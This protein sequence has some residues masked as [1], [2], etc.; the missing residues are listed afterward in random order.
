MVG[1][2]AVALVVRL[3]LVAATPDFR[4]VHDP[5]DYD[6]VARS[7]AASWHFPSTYYARPGT[8]SA[9]VPPLY[10][11]SLGVLYMVTGQSWT[12]GRILGAVLGMAT[13]ALIALIG[14][15]LWG[16]RVG[17][18][19]GALAAV[20]PPLV[21][22]NA[23]LISEALFLPLVL[24]LVLLMLNSRGA[25]SREAL[26]A[27]VAAGGLCGLA[28]LTRSI[29]PALVIPALVWAWQTG[30]NAR[31]RV[32]MAALVVLT[33]AATILPWTLGNYRAFHAFVPIATQ[34]GLTLVG[35]YNAEAAMPGPLRAVWR[36]PFALPQYRTLFRR[37]LDEA[38]ISSRLRSD[39]MD[40]A[41]ENP[42]YPLAVLGLNAPRMFGLGPGHAWVE[43]LSYRE[44]G[45]PTNLRPLTRWSVYLLALLALA[46]AV[47]EGRRR[48]VP[49]FLWV[50]PVVLFVTVLVNGTPRY[51]IPVDPFL[52]LAAAVA[53]AALVERHRPHPGV[54]RA[55]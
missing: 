13:V 6:R 21:M 39:A 17:T 40:F 8:P 3:A 22:T 24:G 38:Q 7:I 50:V 18:V 5:A 16:Q 54:R 36:L 26:V 49:A 55:A 44:M 29:G 30:S 23:S 12:A 51:R 10:P 4:P 52:V 28:A 35:T 33:T 27:A 34:D 15:R 32:A 43:R 11:Y 20:Y 42:G 31:R 45:I 48:R 2:L 37:D 41:L 9:F 25:V 53:I 47:A 19:A 14:L 1:V 46:G